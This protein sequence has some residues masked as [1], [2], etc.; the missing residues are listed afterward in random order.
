[1]ALDALWAVLIHEVSKV[2]GVQAPI[3]TGLRDT[4]AVFHGVSQVSTTQ[5]GDAGHAVNGGIDTPD[6]PPE[7][8]RYQ[9]QPAWPLGCTLDTPATPEKIKPE[10][11]AASELLTGG[12]LTAKPEPQRIFRQRGPGLT[13]TEKS[14]ARAY[15]VH[16]FSCHPCQAAGRGTQY[17]RRCAVGLVLWH[18]YTGADNLQ[19]E[20]GQ[21]GQA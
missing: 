16:H 6:T 7:N 15:H 5:G 18:T 1:M 17:G 3:H 10:A 4:P 20:G 8:V 19:T 13:D 21:H 9:A 2:S 14:A 11:H 12:N